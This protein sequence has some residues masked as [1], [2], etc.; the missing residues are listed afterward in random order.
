MVRFS[1]IVWNPIDEKVKISS[2]CKNDRR[3]KKL[4]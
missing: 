2:C 4:P 3:C 1:D